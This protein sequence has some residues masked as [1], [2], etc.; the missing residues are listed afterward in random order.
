MV[1]HSEIVAVAVES[2]RAVVGRMH[3]GWAGCQRHPEKKDKLSAVAARQV[4]L[5]CVQDT[6]LG[7]SQST[8][9]RQHLASMDV[10]TAVRRANDSE[11]ATA[12]V[13]VVDVGRIHWT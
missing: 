11:A 9:A 7:C 1:V 6:S 10:Q 2:A 12:V 3:L 5:C 8:A 4:T 13:T